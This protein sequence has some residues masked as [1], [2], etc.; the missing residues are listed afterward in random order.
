MD[1]TRNIEHFNL[2]ILDLETTGLDVVTGDSICE[3]GAFKVKS[4]KI[5]DKFH[6]LIN[7]NRNMPEQA[8]NVHKISE[9]ELKDAP[10]FED[11]ADKFVSFLDQSVICAYNIKFDMGFINNHLKKTNRPPLELPAVDILSMARDALKLP[12]YNL[13]AVAKSLNIDCSQGLHRALSDTSVAYQIL[14]KLLDIFKE[15]KIGGLDEFISLY[16]LNNEIF[17]SKEEKKTLLLNAAIEK[18]AVLGIKYFSPNNTLEEEE[19]L[20]LRIL[21]EDRYSYLLCQGRGKGKS[22]SSIKL[23]RILRVEEPKSN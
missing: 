16:G 11:I 4:R 8:Y 21:Q 10:Y 17:K 15:K 22:S 2:V 18:G 3:I 7:P 14:I 19:V 6:S 20:P 23:T 12:R 13:E 9:Q 5:I 1:L